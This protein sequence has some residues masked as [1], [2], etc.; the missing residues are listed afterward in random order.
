MVVL[1]K[2]SS[3]LNIKL[4]YLCDISIITVLINLIMVFIT[5]Q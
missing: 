2:Y 5:L 4:S 1:L 3:Y